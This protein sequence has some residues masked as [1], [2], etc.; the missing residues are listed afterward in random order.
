M[1]TE[2]GACH[3]LSEELN[4]M[5]DLIALQ[6]VSTVVGALLALLGTCDKE[7]ATRAVHAAASSIDAIIARRE[8]TD[9]S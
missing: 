7:A 6:M 9:P 4:P 5:A 2:T 8:T 1:S 3:R